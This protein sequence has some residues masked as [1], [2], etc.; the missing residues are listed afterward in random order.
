MNTQ[1][2]Y[3]GTKQGFMGQDMRGRQFSD[4][5]K[6]RIRER[7]LYYNRLTV[8]ENIKNMSSSKFFQPGRGST[9]IKVLL[10]DH[11]DSTL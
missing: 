2:L 3:P 7:V 11:G 8:C 5:W 1:M 10:K 6:W 9:W 4:I